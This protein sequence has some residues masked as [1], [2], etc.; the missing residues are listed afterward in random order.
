M[1][2]TPALS[3][4]HSQNL[5]TSSHASPGTPP[6]SPP[7]RPATLQQPASVPLPAAANYAPD[8]PPT[9]ASSGITPAK[10]RYPQLVKHFKPSNETQFT[11]EHAMLTEDK[12]RLH[13]QQPGFK[14]F[15]QSQLE[16]AFPAIRPLNPD[17]LSFNRYRVGDGRESLASSEP[18]MA[19]LARMIRDIQANPN[20]LMRPERGIST[21]FTYRRT[22]ADMAV[23]AFTEGTLQS[24]A[25]S[26]AT[27]YPQA[28]EEYWSTPRPVENQP[29]LQMPPQE[30]LLFLHK[31]QLSIL[32]SLRLSD[33]T[34]SATGKDLIDSA[35]RY[36]TLQDREKRF[37]DGDRLGVYPVTVDDQ[38]EHGAMLPGAFL[39]TRKDGSYATPPTWPNGRALALND[40]NG[41]VVMYTPSEGFE[42]FAT[43]AQARQ[44]LASRL[45]QS[46]VEA[47]LL[48]QGLP[49][50]L[51]NRPDPI[52]GKDLMS[53]VEPSAGDVLAQSIPWMLKRQRADINTHLSTALA[54]GKTVNPLLDSAT[55]E[56]IDNAADW[57]YL[58]DGTNAMLARDAKLTDKLQP[59]WLKNLS[60][61]QEAL[62]LHLDKAQER[63]LDALTP[64][65]EK[66]PALNTFARDRL[67]AAIKQRYPAA[68]IDADQLMVQVHTRTAIHGGRGTG[69]PLYSKQDAVSLTDLA[70]KNPSGFPAV[71]RG[72]YT[73]EKM[74][75]PLR[76]KHGKPVRDLSGKPVTLDTDDLKALVNTADVGGEYTKLLKQEMAPDAQSG[77]AV[78]L[79]TAWKAHLADAMDKEAFLAELSPDAYT[80]LA[81]DNIHKRAAQWA[82]AVLTHPD[83]ATRPQV[84]G[85]TIVANSLLHRGLAVQGVMVIG[86]QTD[87]S[88]VLYTPKAPDGITYREVA[89][90]KALDTLLEKKEWATYIAQRKS[91]VSKDEV[92]QFKG[93]LKEAAYS[94][95][96]LMS[97]ELAVSS[98]KL[99]GGATRLEPIKGDFQDHLY[100]QH[101]QM[102][103]DRAD[104]QSVSSAEVARQSLK[105]KIEFGIEVALIFTDLIPVAGKGVSAG[106]R[107]GKA[108]ISALRANSRVLP[109]LIKRP[110]LGRAIYSDFTLSAAG[111]SNVRAAPLRPVFKS[112]TATGAITP[113]PGPRALPAPV[114]PVPARPL[115]STGNTIAGSRT[116]NDAVIPE[117]D[118]SAYARPGD[119]I[120]GRTLRSDGTY[121]VG[122]EWFIRFTDSTRVSRVYQ[123][124]SAFHARSGWVNIIDPNVPA[125]APKS[126][127]IVASVQHAGNGEWRLNQ[128][129]GGA[130][131][132]TPGASTT[133]AEAPAR[134]ALPDAEYFSLNRGRLVEADFTPK[135]LPLA[136]YWFRR[137]LYNFYKNMLTQ[138]Q[139]PPRP[140]R[141]ELAPGTSPAD[142]L[143]KAYEI[144][145]VVV[146][147]ERHNEIASF[148]MLK[149]NMQALKE[150]G[151]T[152]FYIEG[153][154]T[155]AAGQ[156]MDVGMG[157]HRPQGA[158]PTLSELVQ[159][160]SDNGITV[161]SLE[162]HYLTRRSDMPDFYKYVGDNDNGITRLQEF[163]YF[164]TRILETRKP[165]EKVLALVGRAHMNTARNVPGLAELTGGVGI[166]VYPDKAFN[167][168]VAISGPSIPRDPG[169]NVTDSFTAGDYQIFHKVI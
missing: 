88:L 79:R 54:P 132:P 105:N 101:V 104:H 164:A 92:D 21:E 2:L 10:M 42:E 82:D 11:A 75:L 109:H 150:S 50:A 38:T 166:G 20:A 94:P 1:S 115:A 73:D 99:L 161:K 47:K 158:S 136:R 70:L 69:Q 23:P 103:I 112:S 51:Q 100:K 61:F 93:A 127:R 140:S 83:P 106:F 146:L 17:M 76:D 125:T 153:V 30:Q 159:L 110:G 113:R 41:P 130:P 44:A 129:P 78:H 96:K 152:T 33:G 25:R 58:T 65:L 84:D 108:G 3:E 139:M 52:T 15:V 157:G 31:K 145:D 148:Q 149:E 97:P 63:S 12:Q 35:L 95:T 123:I 7:T 26:I 169:A 40:D 156:L 74:T 45:D 102:A 91:P 117:R 5:L 114:S 59:E 116:P 57:S 14:A 55:L 4:R 147:G 64:L 137:D 6:T 8:D 144:T 131:T 29:T 34:L 53:S 46:G 81:S 163:N 167:K 85:K 141:L 90:H 19:A 168:S 43:P 16:E 124:D 119:M 87:P 60:P 22:I 71:E 162:H 77:S 142:L 118:L 39:I 128:L 37:T 121:N 143:R 135:T 18:L 133:G 13:S 86:N 66:I 134:P 36:P 151:V 56:G 9:P 28:L 27:Q 160:A 68:E 122:D 72:V 48:L 154:E 98:I 89:D 24:I 67:N 111:I 49:P 165:G 62:F 120:N 80:E 138:G 155:N 32:A 126:S 107:L